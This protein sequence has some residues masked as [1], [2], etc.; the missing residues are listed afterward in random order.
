MNPR[1][2]ISS[3]LPVINIVSYSYKGGSG[4]STGSVNIAFALAKM[5]KRVV[6]ID[7]DVGAAGLHMIMSEW[8]PDAKRKI[9]ANTNQIGHQN[10]FN[11]TNDRPIYADL[12]KLAPAMLDISTDVDRLHVTGDDGKTG[13][14]LFLF[15]GMGRAFTDLSGRM[16]DAKRFE[17]KYHFL[18]Q[19]LAKK[20]G[21][22]SREG[23]EVYI[24]VDAPNGISPLSLPLLKSADLILMFYRHS[25]QHIRGTIE[26]GDKLH[27]YLMEE[28]D[29]RFMRILLVGSCVPERLMEK[30]K[31]AKDE[32]KLL[33]PYGSDM[34]QK[35][36]KM[37]EDL[38]NFANMYPNIVDRLNDRIIEDDILKILE[39][40][41]TSDGI[42][43]E[44]LGYPSEGWPKKSSFETRKKIRKISEAIASYSPEIIRRKNKMYGY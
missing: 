13:E 22:S 40:P 31:E 30:L 17:N 39:Q 28:M 10:F 9:G 21:G 16:G 3:D 1:Q 18:Q 5:G 26:A 7:M 44:H 12:E 14:L 34:M 42:L 38:N 36:E 43:N 29:R 23:E 27:Y 6:C 8:L 2:G 32:K 37:E 25:L 19:F 33:D 41:L 35:F 11:E 4:R 15:S 20:I 24:I